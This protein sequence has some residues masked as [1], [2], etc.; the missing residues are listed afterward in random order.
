[1]DCLIE[2]TSVSSL[3][4]PYGEHQPEPGGEEGGGGGRRVPPGDRPV[5][6]PGAAAPGAAGPGVAGMDE[7]EAD[8]A[9][10]RAAMARLAATPV[11]D[12]IAN[13]AI[14]LWQLAVLHLGLGGD[15]VPDLEQAALALDAMAALV[16]GLG[17]RL[18]EHAGALRDALAQLRLAYVQVAQ[19]AG[20]S[21]DEASPG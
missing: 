15:V 1:V 13:H 19:A 11:A 5:G 4:T 2:D 21:P 10:I 17:D 7:A 9:E 14:G 12:I 20:A 16:D 18:G 8:E 3:W 6:D